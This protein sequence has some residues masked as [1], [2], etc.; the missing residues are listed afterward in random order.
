ME[1][2]CV[3]FN[4]ASRPVSSGHIPVYIHLHVNTRSVH[5]I[6]IA[7]DKCTVL[8]RVAGYVLL[9]ARNTCFVLMHRF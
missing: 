3:I 7:T 8:M 9:G 4:A 1:F 6:W 5:F 2:E